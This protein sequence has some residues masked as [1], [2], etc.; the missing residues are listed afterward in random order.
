M[1]SSSFSIHPTSFSYQLPIKLNHDNYLF[2][3]FLIL[4]HAR[5]HDLIG[6]LDGSRSPPP[7]TISL[8]DGSIAPNPEHVVW[9]RQDQLL[10]V[11]LLS[12]ISE[13]VVPQ[14]VHCSTAS[15]LWKELH[16]HYSSQSLARVMDLKLQIQLLQKGHLTMQA[17][18]DQKRSLADRLQLIGSPV[19]DA[20]LQLFILHGLGIDYDSLVVSLTSRSDIIPF[21]ELSGLLLTH[22]QRLHKHAMELAGSSSSNPPP[23]LNPS[24]SAL[25]IMPQA[26]LTSTSIL[27]PSPAS[28]TQLFNQFS[29]FLA[30]RGSWRGKGS[31]KSTSDRLVYQLCQ[32]KGHTVDRCYKR[33]DNTYMPPPPRPFHHTFRKS[34]P[35][36]AL[37]VQPRQPI[38]EAWYL[39]SGASTHVSPDLNAFTSYSPYNGPNKL[40]VG[41]GK[42]LDISNVGSGIILTT[43]NPLKLQNILHVPGISKPLISIIQLIVDDNIYVEFNLTSCLVK[44]LSSHQILLQGTKRNGLYVVSSSPHALTCEKLSPHLWHKRFCDA[45]DSIIQYLVNSNSISCNKRNIG[46][47]DSCCLAKANK[48]PFTLSTTTASQV[49]EIV[50]RDVWGSSPIISHNGYRYYVLF[51]D[52]FS[53]YSWIHTMNVAE[54]NLVGS[55]NKAS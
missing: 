2:W 26:N 12:T 16:L 22:E 14:V 25:S 11:W 51:T 18:L 17:Y 39:D 1:A 29:A 3:K 27:G 47:C 13:T 44:D 40:C 55:G 36:Q 4:P 52:Q 35:P 9:M 24:P 42:E 49:L 28:D 50:H 32:K 43:S 37:F 54:N 31:D 15:E 10:L 23:S 8:S 20:D 21:N 41:D 45:S 6:F 48:Q 7:D 5:G 53:R 33:F 19:S 38:P 46:I 34:S 30:S